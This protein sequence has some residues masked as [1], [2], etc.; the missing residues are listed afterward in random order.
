[1][2]EVPKAWR[3]QRVLL[4]FGAVDWR[5][6]VLVNG[7]AVGQHEGGYAPF[8]FDVTGALKKDGPQE[9]VVNVWDPTDFGTQPRGKQVKNPGT[10]FY[11]SVSG[12]W[13]TVW[14]EPV[15]RSCIKGI[16][17]VSDIENKTVTFTIQA[18]DGKLEKVTVHCKELGANASGKTG[19]PI[20]MSV[21]KAKLW[22]PD[23]PTLYP[24]T[25]KLAS[26]ARFPWARIRKGLRG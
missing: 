17:A 16:K 18:E 15:G 6:E 22:S 24:I 23:A 2:F 26:G 11:T 4:H 5:A 13:Q 8:S 9:L 19:E 14:L 3:G 21:P 25:V 7:Q 20:V 10:I 12:I 1:M